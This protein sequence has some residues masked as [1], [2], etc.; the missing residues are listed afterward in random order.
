M[1]VMEWTVEQILQ[2]TECCGNCL[3]CTKKFTQCADVEVDV[4]EK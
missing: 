2:D 4:L 1:S 3:G